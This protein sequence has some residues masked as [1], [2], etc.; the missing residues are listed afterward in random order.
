MGGYVPR[1]EPKKSAPGWVGDSPPRPGAH[2]AII[3]DLAM[4]APRGG[5]TWLRGLLVVGDRRRVGDPRTAVAPAPGSTAGRGGRPEKHCRRGIVTPSCSPGRSEAN[6]VS[7]ATDATKPPRRSRLYPSTD[8]GTL[9]EMGARSD[10]FRRDRQP[11]TPLLLL[12][13]D[14]ATARRRQ[15]H[16]LAVFADP[17]QRHHRRAGLPAVLLYRGLPPCTPL[18]RWPVS[19]GVSKNR[20]KPPKAS[21]AW[22]NTRSGAGPPGIAGPPWPCSRMPSW[23]WPPLPNGTA[24]HPD[25]P[26]HVDGQRVSSTLR[27][28][29]TDHPPHHHQP[30]RLVT[31]ATTTP[32]P[33][34][35]IPLPT[36][37]TPMTTNYGSRSS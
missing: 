32:I 9:A 31:M 35:T 10:T 3:A 25:W 15:R 17:P 36:T 1:A 2:N 24:T 37:R 22:I 5:Q 29:T 21:P 7:A 11:R 14:H 18:S 26:D 23:P 16:R 12:G 13:L 8:S 27:R 30:A 34:P 20:S 33:S 19:A 6:S 4:P 28:S